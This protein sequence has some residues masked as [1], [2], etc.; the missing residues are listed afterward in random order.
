VTD[1]PLEGH[2]AA[3]AVDGDALPVRCFE[4]TKR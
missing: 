3:V 2:A 4:L 1:L